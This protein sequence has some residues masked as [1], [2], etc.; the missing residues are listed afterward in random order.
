MKDLIK[1]ILEAD[2][3][4]A[5]ASESVEKLKI[6]SS[7]KVDS[8]LNERR[9]EYIDKA[10]M[11]IKVIKKIEDSKAAIEMDR[12]RSDCNEMI[13]KLD[14]MYSDHKHEWVD[15]IFDNIISLNEPECNSFELD[16]ND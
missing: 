1:E 8:I 4:I 6:E 2:E 14:I 12:I 3:K 10:R 16:S 13:N 7:N 9:E 5:N 15:Q 11:N